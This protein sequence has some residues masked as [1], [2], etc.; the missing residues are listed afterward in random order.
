MMTAPVL[1]L[2]DFDHPFEIETDASSYGLGAMLQ[3]KGHPIAFIS[4]KLGPKW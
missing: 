1:A 3:Q 2:P 4:K